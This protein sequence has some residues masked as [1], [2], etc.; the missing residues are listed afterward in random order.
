MRDNIIVARFRG[1]TTARTLAVYQYD[2][3][4]MLTFPD[5]TLPAAYEV[6]FASGGADS[7]TVI[8]N[9]DGVAV[10]DILLRKPMSITAYIYLHTGADDGETVYTATIPVT[11]RAAITGETPTPVQQDAITQAIAA[12]QDG[13]ETVQEIADG[14]PDT[15]DAALTEAKESGEFDGPPGPQGE[16]GDKGDTG[17]TGA[18]GPQ[19]PQGETGPQGATG[20]KGDKGDTGAQGPKGDTGAKGDKGDKGDSPVR[21][22]DYWTA[23][24]QAAVIADAIAGASAVAVRY[25]QA[26]TLTDDQKLRARTNISAAA[27]DDSF[28]APMDA[29]VMK[30]LVKD[31]HG[32][33]TFISGNHYIYNYDGVSTTVVYLVNL[34]G[35]TASLSKTTLSGLTLTID[36]LGKLMPVSVFGSA[37][38]VG[39]YCNSRGQTIT[40]NP[41]IGVVFATVNG[42]T[43]TKGSYYA[44][45]A[46]VVDTPTEYV[47]Q[48]PEG[49]THV[50]LG[51]YY[52]GGYNPNTVYDVVYSFRPAGDGLVHDVQ[53]NGTSV[54]SG[55]VANV[56]MATGSAL[57]VVMG[58]PSGG[59]YVNPNNGALSIVGANQAD[60]KAGTNVYKPVLPVYQNEA[61]F[62]GLA[63]AAGSDEK[64]SALPVG[65]YTEEAK[66]AIREMLGIPNFDSEIIYDGTTTENLASVSIT[67]DSNGLPFE[68]RACKVYVKLPASTTGTADYIT[69]R[70]M[71]NSQSGTTYVHTFPTLKM[72]NAT[73]SLMTYEFEAFP[74]GMYYMR[75]CVSSDFNSSS[76]GM[77]TMPQDTLTKSVYGFEIKQY[78][79]T[80]TLIPSGTRI[81]VW[82]IRI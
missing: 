75:G 10:P 20:P 26:Q 50:Y 14:I 41:R 16:K 15:I 54:L 9:A 29:G 44:L 38:R 43:V 19:G 78:S 11:P 22:T 81:I 39:Y 1:G 21:G 35:S 82:G 27:R 79:G 68:L 77:A 56:P 61:V 60:I 70:G 5:L 46:N 23:A 53:V 51:I 30:Y 8:G 31:Q 36:D 58:Y 37:I 64:N 18:T 12:L 32:T 13:V 4:Q 62:Y 66:K 17:A 28:L 74:G 72:S 52:G 48:V 71:M 47:V 25:D 80:S 65:Q 55:G 69:L 3:G 42:E 49:A 67:T 2:Y 57:G 40:R 76:A 59:I 33:K 45:F 24:D 63:K 7:V 73:K 6:H 34:I